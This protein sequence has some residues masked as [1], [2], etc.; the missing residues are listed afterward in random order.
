MYKREASILRM[1]GFYIHHLSKSE[2]PIVQLLII[3]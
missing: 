2:G 1:D 3:L